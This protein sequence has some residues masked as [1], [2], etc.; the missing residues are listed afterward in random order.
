MGSHFRFSTI[1]YMVVAIAAYFAWSSSVMI[2]SALWPSASAVALKLN[3]ALNLG[4]HGAAV[5]AL[6]L[7]APKLEPFGK[8]RAPGIGAALGI[9]LCTAGLAASFAVPELSILGAAASLISGA[10]MGLLLFVWGGALVAL[11]AVEIQHLVIEGAIIAGMFVTIVII[12]LPPYLGVAVSMILPLA[13]PLCSFQTQLRIRADRSE[14][15]GEERGPATEQSAGKHFPVA[16]LL[17]CCA[18]LALPAG[19]YQNGDAAA[20][21]TQLADS[22]RSLVACNCVFVSTAVLLDHYLSQRSTSRLFSRLIVPLM[23]G[24]LLIMAAV[25]TEFGDW[26]GWL[27][28]MGY[29]LFLIYIYTEFAHA[30]DKAKDAPIRVFG[31]GT[32]AIDGGLFLGFAGVS[33]TSHLR[34]DWAQGAILATVYLLLLV[35]ILVFPSVIEQ[36]NLK[37]KRRVAL[38][39]NSNNHPRADAP[40]EH[41]A[42]GSEALKRF[43]DT[44]GLS[45]RE[46]EILRHLATGRTL[47]SIATETCL[48]YNTVKTHVSHIYQKAGVHT[49]DELL[50]ML[51]DLSA[52]KS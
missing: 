4:G 43:S 52:R 37:A 31:I 3:W 49:R 21:G 36:V 27:M 13:I 41:G 6:T 23:A 30:A 17:L 14:R 8:S 5:T 29:Q 7:L 44:H 22:W 19:M 38:E 50:D 15:G 34:A 20:S 33:L 2:S 16:R 28:Q 48:S 18:V 11:R 35:G 24:G 32:M 1:F 40:G 42:G 46:Y 10:C 51:R 12:C 45:T 9:A 26:G 39:M 47:P 25:G